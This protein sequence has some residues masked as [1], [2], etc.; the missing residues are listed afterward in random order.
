MTKEAKEARRIYKREW[1]RKHPEKRRE[2]NKR[3]W[4]KKAAQAAAAAEKQDAAVIE[5]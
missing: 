3:Y 2:Y 5:A 4:E 1:N